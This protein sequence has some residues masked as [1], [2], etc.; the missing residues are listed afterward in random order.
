MH[1][2]GH[3]S[4][5]LWVH[6]YSATWCATCPKCLHCIRLHKLLNAWKHASVPFTVYLHRLFIFWLAFTL[7][8]CQIA[9]NSV[10]CT[11]F[12]NIYIYITSYVPSHIYLPI[13][14]Q[15]WKF[16]IILPW[17]SHHIHTHP[18]IPTH[19]CCSTSE[20]FQM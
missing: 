12:I 8:R 15:Q 3:S 16:L 7:H 1:W 20:K 14:T 13:F 5:L 2:A 4:C 9:K 17:S 11:P 6:I 10:H 19:C 18:V